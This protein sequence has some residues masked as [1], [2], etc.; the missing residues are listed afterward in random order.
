MLCSRGLIDRPEG[1]SYSVK[2]EYS[3]PFPDGPSFGAADDAMACVRLSAK[4]LAEL[5]A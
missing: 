2:K 5:C 1:R 4:H 3:Y